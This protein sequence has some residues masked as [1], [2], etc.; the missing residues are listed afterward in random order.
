MLCRGFWPML[1]SVEG[2]PDAVLL[3]A[4]DCFL[5][6]RGLPFCLAIDLSLT[7]VDYRAFLPARKNG[8]MAPHKESGGRY[9]VG[10]YFALTGS[11]VDILLRSLPPIVHIRKESD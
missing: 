11:H 3:M 7:P 1:L 5:L 10:G 6:W 9:V 4:G 2:V 8:D